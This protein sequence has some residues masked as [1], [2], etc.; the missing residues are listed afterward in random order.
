[1]S[2]VPC[3]LNKIKSKAGASECAR[4]RLIS[5]A[6]QK[7]GKS[8]SKQEG[9]R[10]LAWCNPVKEACTPN[11]CP[12]LTI[13]KQ[14]GQRCVSSLLHERLNLCHIILTLSHE[15][16]G[17]NQTA[18]TVFS[19][20]KFPEAGTPTFL[21][22]SHKDLGRLDRMLYCSSLRSEKEAAK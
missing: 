4:T 10:C 13:N 22:L 20:T 16:L 5:Y 9:Q 14:E 15:D 7:V 1:M 11:V 8:A 3:L 21:T 6:L 19:W 12:H 2:L 18:T 17:G